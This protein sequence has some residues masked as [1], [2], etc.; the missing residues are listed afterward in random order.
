MGELGKFERKLPEERRRALIEATLA[1]LA[2]D[3]H[4]GLSVRKI[5]QEAGIS[6]GLINHHYASKDE[7]VGH[8]YEALSLGLLADI[9]DKV[10]AAGHAP[11]TRLSAYFRASLSAPVLQRSTLRTWVVF[12]G[13]IEHS[14]IMTEVHDRTYAEYRRLLETLLAEVWQEKGRPL[15][16]L[17]LAA[18]GLV[19]IHDGLW[20]EWCLNPDTFSS[21]E[22]IGLCEQWTDAMLATAP[23]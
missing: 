8:A 17:R 19:A 9:R 22:A 10:E 14:A 20:L 1:C 6:V 18:I 15:P 7:L 21:E 4:A 5:S 12:W 23:A 3:G 16:D 2:R 11:R 13:M